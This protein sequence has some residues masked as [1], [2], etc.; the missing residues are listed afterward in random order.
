MSDFSIKTKKD[1][2]REFGALIMRSPY[3]AAGV[4]GG[5]G[6]LS[7]FFLPPTVLSAGALALVALRKGGWFAL[8]VAL[9]SAVPVGL[10]WALADLRPGL[11]S[12][13][14]LVLWCAVAVAAGVLRRTASQ[15][16]ALLTVGLLCVIFVLAMRLLTGD[17]VA[18][19]E[20]WLESA[21]RAV[22]GASVRGFYVE[23]TIRFMNGLFAVLLGIGTMA[24]LLLGRWLQSVVYHPKAFGQEFRELRIPRWVL[25]GS[26]T[27]ILAAGLVSDGLQT[28]LLLVGMM[29]YLFVGLA[30]IHGLVVR[31]RLPKAWA[32]PPYLGLMIA[33]QYALVGLALLGV[34]DGLVNFRQTGR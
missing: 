4:I 32:L 31:R 27:V 12:P 5:A 3:H 15:T 28:D 19:W 9:A 10:V 25:A 34:V 18:F 11:E 1:H 23:G 20:D 16:A 14:V 6:A 22:P 8:P 7:A 26:L 29:T 2:V 13:L 17:V 24:S 30:V 33:P 21:V